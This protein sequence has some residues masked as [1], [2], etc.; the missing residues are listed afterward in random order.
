MKSE[1]IYNGSKNLDLN[2]CDVF[3]H[4]IEIGLSFSLGVIYKL[5]VTSEIIKLIK[6]NIYNI[7]LLAWGY[8]LR[9][10]ALPIL[11]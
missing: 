8:S 9:H 6:G 4:S 5:V 1:L 3:G 2:L 10:L 11:G 7:D